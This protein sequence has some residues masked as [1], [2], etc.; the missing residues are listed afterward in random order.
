MSQNDAF[1]VV[2]IKA[3]FVKEICELKRGVSQLERQLQ[4]VKYESLESNLTE[5]RKSQ[6]VFCRNKILL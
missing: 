1:Q 2:P 6:I 5:I 3:Y 4:T